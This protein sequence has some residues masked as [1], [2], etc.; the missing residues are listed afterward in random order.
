[1]CTRN[2]VSIIA[3]KISE[4]YKSVYGDALVKIILYG[5][6]ARNNYDEESDI[7]LVAIV[8]GERTVLQELLKKIWDESSELELEYETIISPSVIP[9]AEFVKYQNDLPYY[10]NI[11]KEGVEIVA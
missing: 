9:Y 1:M 6:Y 8:K 10:R 7:D 5:S 4:A 11:L 3:K 2:E